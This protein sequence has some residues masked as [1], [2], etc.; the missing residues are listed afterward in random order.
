MVAPNENPSAR[1]L[2]VFSFEPLTF[3]CSECG[4]RFDA[5]GSKT[6]DFLTA[7]VSRHN[8]ERH[9]GKAADNEQRGKAW[10]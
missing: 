3:Q 2:K 10:S 5:S 7:E 6:L 4:E 9:S 1:Q 8:R